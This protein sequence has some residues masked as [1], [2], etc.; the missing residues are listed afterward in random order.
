LYHRVEPFRLSDPTKSGHRKIVALFLVDPN[1]KIISTAYVPCQQ[2]EWWWE[3][4]M[5][6]PNTST[7]GG[8]KSS[9]IG[10][11]PVELLDQIS[12][13]VD[14]PL[15]VK[16]AKDLRSELMAERKVFRL[17]RQESAASWTFSLC[18]H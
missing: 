11:L 13:K 8:S 18:E 14:F 16:E 4:I 6:K 2:Q 12:E 9:T 3:A 1:I 5:A 7:K 15:N 10:N 17:K